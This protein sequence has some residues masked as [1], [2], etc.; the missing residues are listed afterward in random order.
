MACVIGEVSKD[1]RLEEMKWDWYQEPGK[2]TK[3]TCTLFCEDN[4]QL[5]DEWIKEGF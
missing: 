4:S 2:H 1:K 3:L 5:T